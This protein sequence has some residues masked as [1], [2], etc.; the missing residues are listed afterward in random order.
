MEQTFCTRLR[1]S[2][3]SNVAHGNLT[4]ETAE[5]TGQIPE[6]EMT[7]GTKTDVALVYCVLRCHDSRASDLTVSSNSQRSPSGAG[8]RRELI[9]IGLCSEK[10]QV[11]KVDH[12]WERHHVTCWC[13]VKE[14]KTVQ[15]VI[16]PMEASN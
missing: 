10:T 11:M 7:A 12:D 9:H 16:G 15:S 14:T 3:S 1:L 6:E 5:S 13:F 2:N 8:G 4:V